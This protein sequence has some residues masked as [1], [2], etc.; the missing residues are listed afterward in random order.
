MMTWHAC[1]DVAHRYNKWRVYE[2]RE[3]YSLREFV[4][5]RNMAAHQIDPKRGR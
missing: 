3:N 4:A 5:N 1:G 2:S